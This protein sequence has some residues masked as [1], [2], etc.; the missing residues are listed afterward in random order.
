MAMWWE[1]QWTQTADRLRKPQTDRGQNLSSFPYLEK[2]P[3]C[4]TFPACRI[5]YDR[6]DT[7]QV[8]Q[9]ATHTPDI[10]ILLHP[11]SPLP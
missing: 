6:K 5:Q 1:S 11:C 4:V 2:G 3:E 9:G 8:A 10:R 7:P